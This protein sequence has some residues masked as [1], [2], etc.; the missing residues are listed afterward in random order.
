MIPHHLL[1]FLLLQPLYH[2]IPPKMVS[3]LLQRKR[4]DK[5][6]RV[7]NKMS[8]NLSKTLSSRVTHENLSVIYSINLDFSDLV[9]YLY[10]YRHS[11]CGLDNHVD[12]STQN[13]ADSSDSSAVVVKSIHSTAGAIGLGN[14]NNTSEFVVPSFGLIFHSQKLKR[15]I[16]L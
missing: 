7:N 12:T 10:F 11:H 8:W 16:D 6:F 14:A 4:S 5:F 13:I 2:K 9:K 3:T 15:F 1:L